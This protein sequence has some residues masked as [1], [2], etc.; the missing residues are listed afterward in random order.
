V[1]EELWKNLGMAIGSVVSAV[2]SVCIIQWV[3]ND[4]ISYMFNVL[5]LT[6]VQ[7]WKL[8]LLAGA[9]FKINIGPILQM[10][11]SK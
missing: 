9:L 10:M 5:P 1:S 6:W 2:V 8:W 7:S 3:W 4:V 11:R